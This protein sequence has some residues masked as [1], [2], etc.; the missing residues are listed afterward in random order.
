MYIKKTID[1]LKCRYN[2]YFQQIL[3]LI[4]NITSYR[5][6]KFNLVYV[7]LKMIVVM[8]IIIVRIPTVSTVL[9][10]NIKKFANVSQVNVSFIMLIIIL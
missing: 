4:R 5:I 8:M 7:S 10:Q 2:K 6:T 9:L 3:N 1:N